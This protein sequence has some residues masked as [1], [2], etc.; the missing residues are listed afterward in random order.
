M[1]ALTVRDINTNF[2]EILKRVKFG[3]E[4]GILHGNAKTPV[5]MIVPYIKK[6]EIKSMKGFLKRFANPDLILKEKEAWQSHIK[7]KYD[8]L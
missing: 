7:K 4:I 3:E 1:T 8:T 5:A 6:K 2:S